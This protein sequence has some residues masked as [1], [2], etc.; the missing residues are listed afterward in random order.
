MWMVTDGT[1]VNTS[2][3]G[4]KGGQLRF[5][6][7]ARVRLTEHWKESP[8]DPSFPSN[9]LCDLLLGPTVDSIFSAW[10][11]SLCGQ[12]ESGMAP[13]LLSPVGWGGW[14]FRDKPTAKSASGRAGQ[15][16][17]LCLG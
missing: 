6:V 15:R 13:A 10:S 2:A 9:E 1:L 12:G 17:T 14:A 5:C 7:S 3:T 4:E 8:E 16:C 11:R